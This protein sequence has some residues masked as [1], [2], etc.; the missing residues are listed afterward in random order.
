MS[1]I[2]DPTALGHRDVARRLKVSSATV[3]PANW[4][5][6]R[7]PRPTLPIDQNV[8]TL[9]KKRRIRDVSELQTLCRLGACPYAIARYGVVRAATFAAREQEKQDRSKPIAIDALKY[10]KDEGPKLRAAL[11]YAWVRAER[12]IDL[13]DELDLSDVDAAM[14]SEGTSALRDFL[15]DAQA[16]IASAH[17]ELSKYGGNVWRLSFVRALF[18]EWWLLTGKD[19]KSS[20]GPCQD[21]ICA[22][23]CSL[24]PAAAPTDADWGSAI[25]VALARCQP[26]QWRSI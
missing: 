9:L 5:P 3:L 4:A 25:K 7:L 1:S 10:L 15:N 21:F 19:P 2:F 22:A 11:H 8:E 16:G 13:S 18:A 26:G 23:W 17:R 24:S 6:R 20:P 12:L 14:L